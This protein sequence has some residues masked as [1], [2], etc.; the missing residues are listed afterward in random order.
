MMAEAMTDP[1]CICDGNGWVPC[2]NTCNEGYFHDCGEDTCCCLDPEDDVPCEVCGG[3]GVITCKAHDRPG[4]GECSV[5][6]AT[7]PCRNHPL[8]SPRAL[9]RLRAVHAGRNRRER[10]AR[11]LHQRAVL[12]AFGGDDLVASV[13]R[14]AG[15]ATVAGV[16][17]PLV[18]L[19]F[20]GGT[21]VDVWAPFDAPR[22]VGRVC[23]GVGDAAVRD[24]GRTSQRRRR[25]ETLAAIAR[26]WRESEVRGGQ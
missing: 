7:E 26:V 2:W 21:Y 19:P 20:D 12:R 11:K 24:G 9:A 10:N 23:G 8:L 25:W 15:T 13:D 3:R 14:S 18:V 5:C 4:D 6:G 1:E 16:V 17:Y 22:Y